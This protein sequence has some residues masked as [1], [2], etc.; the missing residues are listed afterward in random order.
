[1]GSVSLNI[2]PNGIVDAGARTIGS[3]NTPTNIVVTNAA[4][5]Q[6]VFFNITGGGMLKT[7]VSNSDA[8][9]PIGSGNVYSPV[10]LNNS[11]TVDIIGVGVK[12]GFDYPVGDAT[13]V[14]NKQY[15]VTPTAPGAVNLA[16]S[17]GSITAARVPLSILPVLWCREDRTPVYGW[18][19][20][21]LYQ[22]RV[23]LQA[24]TLRE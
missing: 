2:G 3:S 23:R 11:G 12:T 17:L 6:T 8:N 20:Q 10:R 4:F 16:I 14:V 5:G 22:V 18:N 15:T 7:R 9:Y 19:L 21:Q 1:M 13:K 24:H